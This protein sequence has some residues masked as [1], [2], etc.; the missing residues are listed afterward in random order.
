M[1]SMIVIS[2][3]FSVFGLAGLLIAATS[4]SPSTQYMGMGL[5]GLSWFLMVRYH[6]HRA[7][8]GARRT[9]DA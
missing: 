5:V 3:L 2:A 1:L 8:A 4:D 7:E 9:G 6:G